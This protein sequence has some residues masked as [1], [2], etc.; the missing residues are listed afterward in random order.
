MASKG[1]NTLL[2]LY[3]IYIYIMQGKVF[4]EGA[5]GRE[6][7]TL[8]DWRASSCSIGEHAPVVNG[9]W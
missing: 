1:K 3:S 6:G 5:G 8:S 7:G 2:L 4:L 9:K